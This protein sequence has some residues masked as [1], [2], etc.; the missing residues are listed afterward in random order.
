MWLNLLFEPEVRR[1][2]SETDV[3]ASNLTPMTLFLGMQLHRAPLA[4]IEVRASYSPARGGP[5]A[6][7]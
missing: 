3:F 2:G 5:I 6:G 4:G 1:F 7:V